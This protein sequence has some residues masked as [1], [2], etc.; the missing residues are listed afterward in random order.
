MIPPDL[1]EP[2]PHPLEV[3]IGVVDARRFVELTCR[4]LKPVY[5]GDTLYP[6]LMITALVRQRTT[7]VVTMAATIHNQRG[8]LVLAGEHKYL[9]RL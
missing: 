1:A 9:L 4:F 3:Q 7:G 6:A 5:V 2:A 8:E